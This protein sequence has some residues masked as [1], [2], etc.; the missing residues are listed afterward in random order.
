MIKTQSR[1]ES[2]FLRR[3]LAHYYSHVMTYPFSYITRFYG[4]HRLKMPHVARKVRAVERGAAGGGMPGTS[5]ACMMMR[6][7]REIRRALF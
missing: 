3:I 6:A 2:K 4:M 5:P 7:G 1:A